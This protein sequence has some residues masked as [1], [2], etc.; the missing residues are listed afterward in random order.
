V[1]EKVFFSSS[2]TQGRVII[3]YSPATQQIQFP[4]AVISEIEST[5]NSDKEKPCI[6]P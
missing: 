1:L 3:E 6:Y 5:Y 4:S 2:K